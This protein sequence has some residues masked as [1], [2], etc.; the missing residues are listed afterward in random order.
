MLLSIG[1]DFGDFISTTGLGYEARR[2]AARTNAD[3]W[4]RE[5][6]IVPNPSYGSWD[7]AFYSTSDECD[8]VL[9]KKLR[10]LKLP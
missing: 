10:A 1:D 8:T 7:R 5:W 6:I 4:G 9:I 2:T 3:R